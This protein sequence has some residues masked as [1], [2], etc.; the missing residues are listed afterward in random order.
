MN[1]KTFGSF[2]FQ[3]ILGSILRQNKIIISS[4][5][6]YSVRGGV[7]RDKRSRSSWND[8]GQEYSSVILWKRRKW[9]WEMGGGG[10]VWCR[11]LSSLEAL[12]PKR[13]WSLSRWSIIDH[14][15]VLSEPWQP[16]KVLV[17]ST[18]NDY[19]KKRNKQKSIESNLVS[20]WLSGS[21]KKEN[22]WFVFCAYG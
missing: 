18:P 5:I 14:G 22:I 16:I 8:N 13:V 12:P 20:Y 2:F 10:G 11:V 1:R 4:T 7:L 9:G 3:L 21:N 6:S 15:M 17:F 19:W